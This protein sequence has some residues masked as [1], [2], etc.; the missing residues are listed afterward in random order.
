[1]ANKSLIA[2][3]AAGIIPK[4][5][6]LTAVPSGTGTGGWYSI[7]RESFG[8]AFQ[9]GISIDN[10]KNIL[11]FSAVFASITVIASD[12]AKLRFNIVEE[13]ENGIT[14]KV[15]NPEKIKVL[16]RPNAYQNR[17]K[18]IEQWV[19][20]KLL[21]GNAYVL[22]MRDEQRKVIR[23]HV[24]DATKVTP[25]VTENGDVFYEIGSDHV[26]GVQKKLTVPASEII[27]D[28]MVCLWHPLIGVSPIYAC[29]VSATM[30]N[31]IQANSTNFF[32]NMSRPSGMLTAPGTIDP[33][34]ANRLKVYWE[35]NFNGGNIG[36]LAVMGD[37][38]KYEAMTVPAADAQLIEQLRWTVEDVARCFK[39]PIYK[40]GGPI[41]G[42]NS[43]EQLNQ[44]YYQDCLQ[45]LIEQMEVSLDIGLDVPENRRVEMNLDD[46]LRMDQSAM[47][48]MEAE[49][50][51]GGIK[52]PNES[53]K[54]M[55]LLP[56]EGGDTAYLQQQNFSLEALSKRDA[57]EDPFAT[58]G[59]ASSE[60]G[61]ASS[62]GG[63]SINTDGDVAM[64]VPGMEHVADIMAKL[65]RTLRSPVVPI[66]DDTGKVIGS[67]RVSNLNGEGP[68]A[69]DE[70]HDEMNFIISEI[71]SGFDDS[72]NSISG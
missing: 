29:G 48:K 27:H 33:E 67:R 44:M 18:F 40:I 28:T 1:M 42:G 31:K 50:V 16:R 7:L 30:G 13:D 41:P 25:L 51:K 10:P 26:N 62:G 71:E 54:R 57:K 2:T 45:S 53:R 61:G 5:R 9:S 8:G 21:Y 38:L 72:E 22:M 6:T 36:R 3:L 46:L 17:I 39:I 56:L 20:S 63:V 32:D 55:N 11:A 59:G 60:D 37:G 4:M 12:I 35:E 49:G 24:L 70:D 15:K 58:G 14:T 19:V 43:I 64:H 52:A 34:T 47:I 69:I 65:D 68:A 66:Y 23:M